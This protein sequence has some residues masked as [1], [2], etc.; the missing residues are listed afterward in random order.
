[1]YRR[2][3]MTEVA[4][5]VIEQLNPLKLKFARGDVGHVPVSRGHF[6]RNHPVTLVPPVD[7]AFCRSVIVEASQFGESRH[8]I[9]NSRLR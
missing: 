5:A 8:V 4:Q 1:M 9:E 2:L 7:L 6:S 3:T